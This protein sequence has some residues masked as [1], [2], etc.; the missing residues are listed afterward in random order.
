[1][2]KRRSRAKHRGLSARSW[3]L[4]DAN[5]AGWIRRQSCDAKA[6]YG[7]YLA[8]VV[9]EEQSKA[10]GETIESYKCPFAPRGDPHWHIG[11]PMSD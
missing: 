5:E 1:V 4:V 6:R 10:S 11:H 3:P 2:T 8:E 7:E 9:A